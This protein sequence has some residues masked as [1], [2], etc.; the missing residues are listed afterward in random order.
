MLKSIL[1]RRNDGFASAYR[2]PTCICLPGGRLIVFIEARMDSLSDTGSIRV[3]ARISDDGGHSFSEPILVAQDGANTIGNPC[4][5]FD[6]DTGVLFLLLNQNMADGGE[7]LILQGKAKRKVYVCESRDLGETWSPLRDITGCVMQ[8][9]WTWHAVGPC[10]A[11]Q[12]QSGR[13]LVPCNH[14]VLDPAAEK[15]GPYISG[16]IFSDDHGATWHAGTDVGPYTNECSLAQLQDGTVYMNMRSYAGKNRRAVAKSTNEGAS[17]SEIW[18]DGALVE[19]VCQGSA[20]SAGDC[21]YFSNPASIARE[22]LTLRRSRDF[23]LTW[24]EKILLHEGPAAYSDIARLP[25]GTLF[26]VYECGEDS[27]YERIETVLIAPDSF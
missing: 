5:V 22:K 7:E 23:G 2:I 25:D 14:A 18:L 10:H 15:S 8:D 1:Y 19:P 27:P 17:W 6:S 12:L 20:L 4:P 26:A 24:P 21:L 11:G 13:L 9:H 16:T 3:Q